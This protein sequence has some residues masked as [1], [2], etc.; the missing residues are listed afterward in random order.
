MLYIIITGTSTCGLFAWF[1]LRDEPSIVFELSVHLAIR[2]TRLDIGHTHL[3]SET[4]SPS[5]HRPEVNT[6]Q[7]ANKLNESLQGPCLE[8]HMATEI[9]L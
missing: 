7:Y 2:A 3:R 1:L 8:M 6:W 9:S 5:R 4:A